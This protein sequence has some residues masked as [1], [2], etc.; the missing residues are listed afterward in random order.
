MVSPQIRRTPIGYQQLSVTTAVGLTPPSI[1]GAAAI[2]PNYAL[3]IVEGN[4]VR[5]R[6]D[7]VAPTAAVGFPLAVGVAFEYEGL[8]SA[9]QFV[10]Q[11][12]TATVNVA[13][14]A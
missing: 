3:I 4:A 13:Y 11:S 1:D 14:Y 7:G 2:K 10:S 12:G 5:W 8:L 6:D 9:I